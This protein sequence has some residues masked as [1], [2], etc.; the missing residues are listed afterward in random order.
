M[1]G[2]MKLFTGKQNHIFP[3]SILILAVIIGLNMI[4]FRSYREKAEE[5]S[6]LFLQEEAETVQRSLETEMNFYC[7]CARQAGSEFAGG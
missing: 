7:C 5:I 4:Q 2:M 1:H 6:S 3:F